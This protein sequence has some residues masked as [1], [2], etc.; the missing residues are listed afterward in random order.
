M[1]WHGTGIAPRVIA[2]GFAMTLSGCAP[3]IQPPEPMDVVLRGGRVVDPE[4]ATDAVLNVGIRNGKIAAISDEPLAGAEE[5]DVSGLV[6]APGFIDL[7]VHQF[8]MEQSLALYPL[9]ARDGVTTALELEIGTSNVSEWYA[10]REGGQLVN[11]GVSVGHVPVRIDVMGDPEPMLP[12]GPAKSEEAV[13]DQIADMVAAFEQGLSDGA[14]AVGFGLQYTPGA[15]PLEIDQLVQVAADRGAPIHVHVRGSSSMHPDPDLTGTL[16]VISMADRFRVPVHIAHAN[17]IAGPYLGALLR[18]VEQ[19]RQRGVDVTTETYPYGAG[20]TF[21]NSSTFDGWE[22]YSEEQFSMLEWATTGERL[23][24]ESFARLRGSGAPVLIHARSEEL[25]R[26]AVAS[27]LTMIASDAYLD[28]SGSGHPRAAGTSARILGRYVREDSVLSLSEALQKMTID[29]ARRLEEYVP[30]MR[31]KGRLSTGADADIT[32]FDA[33]TIID[34]ATYGDPARPP[35]GILFVF[36]NGVR[37]VRN[38]QLVP[39]VAPGTGVRAG[40]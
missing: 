13:P 2:L 10:E 25:T 21:S 15:S 17:A 7:H 6:V 19:A 38:G 39:G 35:D 29:P 27:P 16:E 32:V 20:M 28:A 36:V 30:A 5:I 40:H 24:R 33:H 3:T 14:L 4:S 1:S 11:Y 8:T 37:V 23:T 31:R 26:Q 34:R 18:T 9:L 22:S 12:G